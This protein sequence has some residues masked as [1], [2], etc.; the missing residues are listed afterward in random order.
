MKIWQNTCLGSTSL[1]VLGMNGVASL[2]LAFSLALCM[3][4]SNN[5]IMVYVYSVFVFLQHSVLKR[6]L[7]A[8]TDCVVFGA[9]NGLLRVQA[10]KGS[11]S[12]STYSHDSTFSIGNAHNVL[13]PFG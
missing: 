10:S 13:P 8:P 2:G 12:M 4:V 9:G 7:L 11:H 1:V 5:T 3:N 6:L